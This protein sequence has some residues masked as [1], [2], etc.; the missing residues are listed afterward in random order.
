MIP[1][2]MKRIDAYCNHNFQSNS[3]TLNLDGN[4]K[5]VLIIPPPYVPVISVSSV[6]VDN[7]VA[8]AS[9]IKTYDTHIAYDNSSFRKDYQNVQ[10]VLN[11]GYTEVPADLEYACAQLVANALIDLVRRKILPQMVAQVMQAEG[12]NASLLF[13]SPYVFTADIKEI[14]NKYRYS[15]MGVA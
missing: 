11:Y 15:S 9:D 14:L 12:G 6:T 10:V 8:T 2:A 4:N 5:D 7:T 13:A 1:A 3:G